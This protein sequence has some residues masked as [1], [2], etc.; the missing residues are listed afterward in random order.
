MSNL[1]L[2]DLQHGRFEDVRSVGV[3]LANVAEM[4]W[5]SGWA[6]ACFPHSSKIVT[7]ILRF[8]SLG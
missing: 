8:S 7:H 5:S 4:A 1:S 3:A 6:I 2:D